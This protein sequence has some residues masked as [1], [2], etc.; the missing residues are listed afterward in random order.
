[1]RREPVDG[2]GFPAR[3][4]HEQ[5]RIRADHGEVRETPA[6]LG[7]PSRDSPRKIPRREPAREPQPDEGGEDMGPARRPPLRTAP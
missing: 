3:R 1:M 6:G 5:A 7:R 4:D 2:D